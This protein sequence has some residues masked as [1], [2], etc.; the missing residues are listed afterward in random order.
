MHSKVAT[1]KDNGNCQFSIVKFFR[2]YFYVHKAGAYLQIS[3]LIHSHVEWSQGTI[4]S[5]NNYTITQ[6]Q[7][8]T[9]TLHKRLEYI[10]KEGVLTCINAIR[11]ITLKLIKRNLYKDLNDQ[12]RRYPTI[13]VPTQTLSLNVQRSLIKRVSPSVRHL[14]VYW[15]VSLND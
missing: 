7:S 12:R 11:N 5:I 2:V 4:E 9:F 6:L 15:N 8:D 10:H 14:T 13:L 3:I 1:H